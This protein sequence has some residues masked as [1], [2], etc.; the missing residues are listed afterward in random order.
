M[1]NFAKY[2]LSMSD[3]HD[4]Q[5]VNRLIEKISGEICENCPHK[6]LPFEKELFCNLFMNTS[7]RSFICQIRRMDEWPMENALMTLI[8]YTCSW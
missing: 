7:M 6:I 1:H 5:V 2:S 8:D 3:V 4:W